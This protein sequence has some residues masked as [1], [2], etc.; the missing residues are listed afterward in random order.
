[1]EILKFYRFWDWVKN[2]GI[3]FLG[4]ISSSGSFYGVVLS[5]INAGLLMAF[6]F[7]INDFYDSKGG[8]KNFVGEF[9]KRYGKRKTIFLILLPF[10]ASVVISTIF[11]ILLLL[12]SLVFAL[13]FYVYSAPPRLRD[14]WYYSLPINVI[15][16]GF[17]GFFLGF[18]AS[19]TGSVG[20]LEL[21]IVF[22]TSNYILL[23]EVI[24]QISHKEA[25]KKMG[26][27]S[28][29]NDLGFKK[30]KILTEFSCL[31]GILVNIIFSI[32]M[33]PFLFVSLLWLLKLKNVFING[34][35]DSEKKFLPSQRVSS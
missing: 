30:A 2:L 27:V 12:V 18:Y 4:S 6:A 29:I 24:H 10:F 20:F 3:V 5:L 19:V 22:N 16:L 21:F 32:W 15:C 13:L 7:S 25:D 23:S 17:L 35:S 8:E 1:M 34:S 26:V 28:I 11:S 9:S 31:L 33:F 14:N